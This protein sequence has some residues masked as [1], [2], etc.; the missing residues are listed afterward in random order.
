M[1]IRSLPLAPVTIC[2]IGAMIPNCLINCVIKRR[3]NASTLGDSIA[4][5]SVDDFWVASFGRRH[6]VDQ[7]D[8]LLDFA[9]GVGAIQHL[10]KLA[11]AWHERNHL[12]HQAWL[13]DFLQHV[14][15]VFERELAGGHARFQLFHALFRRRRDAPRGPQPEYLPFP[16]CGWHAFWSEGLEGI[17]VF[18][19]ADEFDRH[20]RDMLDAQQRPAA[21]VAVQLGHDHAVQVERFVEGRR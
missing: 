14:L 15:E 17:E 9:I 12:L 21:G 10:A 1:A 7:A 20:L 16:E 6:R 8:H 11:H 3:W 5:R 19:G 18:A 4:A 2:I 13:G